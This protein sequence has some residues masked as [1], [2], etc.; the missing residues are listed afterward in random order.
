LALRFKYRSIERPQ[1]LGPKTAPIISLRLFG[2]NETV[3]DTPA[4]VD[5][6]AD[7][8]VIFDEHAEILGLDLEKAEKTEV[9]GIGG[10]IMA[11]RL[12]IDAEISGK[13]EHRKF[14][15]SLPFM[16]L[17]KPVENH[18]ILLGRAGFFER[19]EITFKE[20]D[21]EVILKPLP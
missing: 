20:K 10:K 16:V 9:C 17:P 6:G 11:W 12:K 15:F 2:R 14:R 5:S 7:Y 18:P 13:G 21:R 8:S 3:F 19:F 1:P 4:L